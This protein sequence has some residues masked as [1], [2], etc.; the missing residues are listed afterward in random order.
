MTIKEKDELI[1]RL[2]KAL[3]AHENHNSLLMM[4]TMGMAVCEA[5]NLEAAEIIMEGFT[6]QMLAGIKEI[7]QDEKSN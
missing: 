1:L 2:H 5:P 6:A 4:F 3:K 7:Q